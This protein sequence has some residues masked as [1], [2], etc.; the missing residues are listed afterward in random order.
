MLKINGVEIS[1]NVYPN[2]ESAIIGNEILEA[3]RES[4]NTKYRQYNEIELIYEDDSDLM[5]LMFIKKF[6]DDNTDADIYLR[7]KYIPYS[8]MDRVEGNSV[9]TLKYFCE[10]INNLN[11]KVI[12]I[13]EAHSEVS[14]ALL[15]NV[16][17]KS[18]SLML[19]EIAME[20]LD[21]DVN[22]DYIYYPD[23]TSNRRYSKHI[24]IKN[25][26][27]G[28]KKRNFETGKLESLNIVG[29][30]PKED[31][32]DS[33]VIMIDDLCSFG[34]T[35]AWGSEK[36]QE[37]GFKPENIYLVVGHCENSIFNGKLLRDEVRPIKTVFTTNSMLRD[38]E[39]EKEAIDKGYLKV[40]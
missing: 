12:F 26:L 4:S 23:A 16:V 31:V 9:F 11:F 25:E 28:L 22:K 17:H 10:F 24:N 38:E 6:L 8:R 29:D 40:W 35:F 14:L 36:L 1:N 7:M 20:E 32:K 21:F 37:L 33:K 13:T 2:G 30:I 18:T 34:G 3:Y 39:L 27:I 15:N 19:L 5:R